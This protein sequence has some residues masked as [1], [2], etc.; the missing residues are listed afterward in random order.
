[1]EGLKL[2]IYYH[3]EYE[4]AALALA[5]RLFAQFDEQIE[6]LALTPV[7]DDEFALAL[8]GA[9]LHSQHATGTAPRAADVRAILQGQATSTITDTHSQR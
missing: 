7:G 3:M 8:N 5:R 2:D 6:S 1:M 9:I 4:D